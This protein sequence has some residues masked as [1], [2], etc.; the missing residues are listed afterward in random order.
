[1]ALPFPVLLRTSLGFR[2]ANIFALLRGSVGIFMFGVQTYFL[3]KAI[4]YLI[5]ISNFFI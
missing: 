2:G 3:S 1:M 4:S 5:R